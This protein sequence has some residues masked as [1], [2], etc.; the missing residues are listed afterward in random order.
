MTGWYPCCCGDTTFCETTA[1]TD[2]FSTV[3]PKWVLI[4]TKNSNN[5]RTPTLGIK[6]DQLEFE[7]FPPHGFAGNQL[8]GD[9]SRCWKDP[10]SST[11]TRTFAATITNPSWTPLVD[12]STEIFTVYIGSAFF[13]LGFGLRA[14][15]SSNQNPIAGS[16][17]YNIFSPGVFLDIPQ[18][19]VVGDV[20]KVK[21]DS[22]SGVITFTALVNDIAIYTRP[23]VDFVFSFDE[24][25]HK[26]RFGVGF[27]AVER[28]FRTPTGHVY[29]MDDAVW[30]TT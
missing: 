9:A 17:F 2:D 7:T 25:N 1:F 26:P 29:A 5:A 19:P 18:A 16:T 24:G 11:Y 6:N 14:V 27:D 20:L 4:A 12:Y 10:G 28:I 8:A 3:E 15:W 13:N 30:G 21:I 23:D 22:V